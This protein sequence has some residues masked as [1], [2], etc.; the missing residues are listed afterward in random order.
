M[1]CTRYVQRHIEVVMAFAHRVLPSARLC[2]QHIRA[3]LHG[4]RWSATGYAQSLIELGWLMLI[5]CA[6][7]TPLVGNT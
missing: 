4:G 3:A 7:V 1:E 5:A 2:G 6:L